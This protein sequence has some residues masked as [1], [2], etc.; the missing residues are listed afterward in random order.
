MTAT[1]RAESAARQQ[2]DDF[3]GGSFVPAPWHLPALLAG[4]WLGLSV[5]WSAW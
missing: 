3:V 2:N 5:P 1:P 4:I